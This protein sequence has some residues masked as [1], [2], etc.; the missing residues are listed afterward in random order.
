MLDVGL[1]RVD[2]PGSPFAYANVDAIV[3]RRCGKSVTTMGVP[4]ARAIAGPVTLDTGRVMPFVGAHTAQNLVKARQRFMKDLV[5]PY[6]D[7]MSPAVWRAGVKLRESIGDTGLTIDPRTSG[8]DWRWN[9]SSNLSVFAPTRSSVRGDGIMHLTFDEWLVFNRVV[10]ADLLAA[11]G[12]T[13]GDARGHGQIWRVSN[14]SILNNDQTALW[15]MKERG[16]ATVDAGRTTG[17]AYFEFTVPDTFDLDDEESWWEFYPALGDGIIRI[18]ELREDRVRLGDESFGAEY[19]GRWPG[20][21]AATPLWLTI[22]RAAWDAAGVDADDLEL[23]TDTPAALGVDIDPYDR[24]TTIT[25]TTADP[26]RDGLM[27]ETIDDRPGSSWVAQRIRDLAAGVV[28]IGIDDYGPGHDLILTLEADPAVS[29]KLVR[30]GSTDLAAACFAWDS[31]LRAGGLRVRKSDHYATLSQSVAGVQRTTGK[32]WQWERRG[33][34][35]A[36][37]VMSATLSAWALGRAPEPDRFFVY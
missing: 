21:G 23:P 2:G 37:G 36:T 8:K 31:R 4:L 30:M 25:A 34:I 12:P 22:S 33:P 35:P 29:A 6:R 17:T 20:A 7:S 24:V 16:R 11:A 13:L 15:E 18:E 32:S 5:E 10:G 14:V 3:G 1:E 9:R 26:G 27:Q 28:A 19:F